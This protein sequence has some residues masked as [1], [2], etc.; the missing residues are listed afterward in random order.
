MRSSPRLRERRGAFRLLRGLLLLSLAAAVSSCDIDPEFPS[1]PAF[2][3]IKITNGTGES[4]GIIRYRPAGGTNNAE[5]WSRNL[6]SDIAGTPSLPDGFFVQL[7][8]QPGVF[9]FSFENTDGSFVWFAYDV[10]VAQN[11]LAFHTVQ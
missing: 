6:M 7:R 8:L 2:G 1:T 3:S 9:D 5:M 10:V 11:G 4:I